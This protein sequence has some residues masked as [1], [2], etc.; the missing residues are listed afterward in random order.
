MEVSLLVLDPLG[1]VVYRIVSEVESEA[2][3]HTAHFDAGAL[4][5]GVY[6][7]RLMTPDKTFTRKMILLR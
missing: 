1:R 2:G 7:Y 6:F 5:S 3:R 4:P